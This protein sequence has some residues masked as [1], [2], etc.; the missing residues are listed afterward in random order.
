MITHTAPC[1]ACGASRPFTPREAFIYTEHLRE[2][3]ASPYAK[4]SQPGAEDHQLYGNLHANCPDC[5]A[6]VVVHFNIVLHRYI[7]LLQARFPQRFEA[8]TD[9]PAFEFV[10]RLDGELSS[11]AIEP[12]IQLEEAV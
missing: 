11:V 7:S 10:Q 6:E 5:G 2:L 4:A 3:N 12:D 1:P 8:G 9:V